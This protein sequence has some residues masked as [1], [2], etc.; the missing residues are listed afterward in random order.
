MTHTKRIE[1]VIWGLELMVSD[2]QYKDR[3][4]SMGS[5]VEGQ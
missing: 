5:K 1:C 3:M 2:T 4:C